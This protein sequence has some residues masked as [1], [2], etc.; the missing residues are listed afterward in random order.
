M[1][2]L[3]PSTSFPKN[4]Q[5][6]L[7]LP[8]HSCLVGSNVDLSGLLTKSPVE[9]HIG[10]SQYLNITNVISIDFPSSGMEIL[11]WAWQR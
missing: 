3:L 4:Q 8:F 10:C 6:Y 7:P 11:G 5:S 1:L 2:H 9:G